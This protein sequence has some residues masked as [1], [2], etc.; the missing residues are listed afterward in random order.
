MKCLPSSIWRNDLNNIQKIH[1]YCC[2]G[3]SNALR[4]CCGYG[5][6]Y[7][8]NTQIRCGS[9]GRFNGSN[10]DLSYPCMNPSAHASWDGIHP[11][12]QMNWIVATAFMRGKHITPRGGFQCSP[13]YSNWYPTCNMPILGS[14]V[15][16]Q[17]L[18]DLDIKFVSREDAVGHHAECWMFDTGS[19]FQMKRLHSCVLSSDYLRPADG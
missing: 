9:R 15:A 7:N 6:E 3:I 8:F 14:S 17:P 18:H 5:G 12:Q 19:V 10:L 11:S 2:S 13:D 1:G 4:A 16:I